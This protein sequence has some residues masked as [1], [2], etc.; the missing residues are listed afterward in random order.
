MF[1]ERVSH[2]KPSAGVIAEDDDRAIPQSGSAKNNGAS[3]IERPMFVRIANS[4]S[5]SSAF[6]KGENAAQISR[7]RSCRS[8]Q[9]RAA[10]APVN[11]T[12]AFSCG[13]ASGPNGQGSSKPRVSELYVLGPICNQ[14]LWAF[15][16]FVV[17]VSFMLQSKLFRQR[18]FLHVPRKGS[19]QDHC[20]S[21]LAVLGW[22]I[23][24]EH[25]GSS[26]TLKTAPHE[27]RR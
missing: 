9:R 19:I 4:Q 12:A 2:V 18:G 26:R 21:G 24:D 15:E 22:L 3:E 10:N 7:E 11:Q 1:A 27:S 25:Y 13:L 17:S 23:S 5:Q 16:M 20:Q 8:P 14:F 6:F